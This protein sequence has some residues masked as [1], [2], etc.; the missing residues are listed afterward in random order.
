MKF[1]RSRSLRSSGWMRNCILRQ[2]KVW[3]VVLVEAAAPFRPVR[4]AETLKRGSL[5]MGQVAHD[6]SRDQR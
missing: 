3:G 1:L 2:S 4:F 6:D 5:M